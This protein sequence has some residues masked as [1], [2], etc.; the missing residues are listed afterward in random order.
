MSDDSGR[1]PH[2]RPPKS[3]GRARSLRQESTF[4]ERLLWGLL[5]DERLRGLKFRRQQPI[6]PFIADFYCDSAKLVIEID[7][8]THIGT[9]E[10]D[11]ERT[12]YME[13]QGLHVIRFT[14]DEVIADSV[15]VAEAIAR[16]AGVTV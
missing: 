7:G 11:E 10:R 15:L 8:L 14:N 4:P 13:Q 16:A 9:G 12:T 2:R 5:R 1:A 3:T 6:G